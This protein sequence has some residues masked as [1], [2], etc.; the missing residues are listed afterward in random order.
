MYV[1]VSIH[2][3]AHVLMSGYLCVYMHAFAWVLIC[4]YMFVY[5]INLFMSEYFYAYMCI[6]TLGKGHPHAPARYRAR[7]RTGWA[8]F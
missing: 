4:L 1:Y 2:V 3:H 8:C 6:G 7:G 5:D